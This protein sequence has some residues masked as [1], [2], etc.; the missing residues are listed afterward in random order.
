MA[1]FGEIFHLDIVALG[2]K[3]VSMLLRRLDFIDTG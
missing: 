1:E 3:G 2:N